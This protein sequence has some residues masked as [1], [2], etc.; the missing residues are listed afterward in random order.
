MEEAYLKLHELGYA[1][2][3]EVWDDSHLVGGLYGVSLGKCFFGESMFSKVSNA[4]KTAFVF[5]AEKLKEAA[6]LLIDCQIYSYHLQL[7][8]ARD[9]PRPIFLKLL[10]HALNAPT[11]RGRWDRQGIL[12]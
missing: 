2:S 10:K 12:L 6:F 3:V 11:H 7:L 4:S 5:L 1:H 9:V 8:G